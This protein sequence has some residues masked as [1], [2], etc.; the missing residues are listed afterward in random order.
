VSA[1]DRCPRCDA[2][3]G[4]LHRPGCTAEPC[5][6]CGGQ[7]VTCFCE[8][9]DT[10]VPD[11]DRM[12][13]TGVWP[14]VAEAREFGWFARPVPGEGWVPCGPNH[15]AARTDLNRLRVDATWDREQRQWVRK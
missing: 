3:V 12:A 14:G 5:P 15:L 11:D 1:Q 7:L 9:S 2:A 8:D 10:G 4:A 6:Y 13:W